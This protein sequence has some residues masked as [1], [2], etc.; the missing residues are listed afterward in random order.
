MKKILLLVT[1]SLSICIFSF[2]DATLSAEEQ[3]GKE[4]FFSRILSQD[5]SISCSSCHKP[6]FAFSDNV[7][8]SEGLYDQFTSRNTPSLMHLRAFSH[9]SWDGSKK[10]LEE[11]SI[12]PIQNLAEMGMPIEEAITRLINNQHFNNF[13]R[14]VYQN[15]PTAE[16][17]SKALAAYQKTLVGTSAYDRYAEGETDAISASAQ[18]G[19]E[20]FGGKANC[21]TCH[22]GDD[23]TEGRFENIGTYDGKT[24][25]DK[26]RGAVTKKEEDNGKFK[27]PSLRNIAIT[28][29]YMHD[30]SMANLKEVI[31]YYNAPLKHRPNAIGISSE[32]KNLD[33]TT[34]EM[35]DLEA[36][37]MTLTGD[38]FLDD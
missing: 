27:V 33:L 16:N 22:M 32:V 8:L 18:R 34:D 20:L 13:F 5:E 9:F 2:R 3:L 30:G 21:T 28:A 6:Q 24:Y 17:L 35:Q 7:A 4:L 38:V 11:Q 29:P 25:R 12:A 10:T 19:L 14:L 23:F 15:I 26:G 1:T 37:L 31:E 36:F